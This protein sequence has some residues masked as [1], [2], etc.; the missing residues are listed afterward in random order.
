MRWCIGKSAS[1]GDTRTVWKFLLVPRLIDGEWRW[2]EISGIRQEFQE[3][4]AGVERSV[5]V[6][7]WRDV[8]WDLDYPYAVA[9]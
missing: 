1:V 2:L 7:G 4:T 8:S 3:F 9:P 5:D 6:V